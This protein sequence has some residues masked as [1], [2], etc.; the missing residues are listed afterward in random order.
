MAIALDHVELTSPEQPSFISDEHTMLRYWQ[1]QVPGTELY[2][3]TEEGFTRTGEGQYMHMTQ[4]FVC[5]RPATDSGPAG[6]VLMQ[7]DTYTHGQGAI[8]SAIKALTGPHTWDDAP[9]QRMLA[10]A[11]D[12]AA[13]D[14]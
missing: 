10:E 12:R 7:D 13:Q 3:V 14:A 6:D 4:F 1:A 2:A 8:A 11:M 5:G 9:R